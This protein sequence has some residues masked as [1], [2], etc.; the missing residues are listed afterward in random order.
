MTITATDVRFIK[1]GRKGSWERD[2]I[3]S[4]TP[5][6]RFGFSSPHHN[7]C[8]A[9]DWETVEAYWRI[10]EPKQ[11]AKILNQTRDFYELN[12]KT[13][14][15]TF[16]NRKLYWCFANR[17]VLETEPNGPRVRSVKGAW[18]CTD[19]KDKTLFTDSLNGQ[20]TKIQLF[21]G[22]MCRVKQRDYLLSRING[23]VQQDVQRA[24]AALI[25]I[26]SSIIPLIRMLNWKDF[27][28]LVD[29]IFSRNG[30]QRLSPLGKTEKSIDLDLI[31]PITARRAFVQVKSEASLNDLMTSI[32]AF[33][34]MD[35]YQDMFFVVHTANAALKKCADDQ[36]VHFLGVPE[37]SELVIN[38]GLSS[39]IMQKL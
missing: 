30:F 21:Q 9:G 39:W 1:L 5:T 29:L 23:E 6:I 33:R 2:C 13:L 15:I 34:A 4:E 38:S 26:K 12:S 31:L 27:E 8:L 17:K 10:K 3:D 18:R 7:E 22:T 36:G 25:E 32:Q 20:L 24:S 28:L 16:Y 19:V 14:W 37:I 11:A 35:Q